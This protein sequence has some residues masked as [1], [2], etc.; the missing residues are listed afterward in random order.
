MSHNPAGVQS[1]T[2][3]RRTNQ[4]FHENY[5]GTIRLVQ[6]AASVAMQS[7]GKVITPGDLNYKEKA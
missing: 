6:G 5:E 2:Q 3:T 4:P 7:G 1:S